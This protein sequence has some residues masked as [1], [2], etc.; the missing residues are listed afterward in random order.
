MIINRSSM[1][2]YEE[3]RQYVDRLIPKQTNIWKNVFKRSIGNADCESL[4]L[5]NKTQETRFF[6][7]NFHFRSVKTDKTSNSD[8]LNALTFKLPNNCAF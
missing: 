8:G 5:I 4:T 1:A 2:N 6:T 3:T 7:Q